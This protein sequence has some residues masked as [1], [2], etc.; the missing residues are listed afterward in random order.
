[1]FSAL[2]PSTSS[3][4]PVRRSLR[5]KSEYAYRAVSRDDLTSKSSA[6]P[7]TTAPEESMMPWNGWVSSFLRDKLGE[8]RYQSLRKLLLYRPDDY[9][10]FEQ[11][12][13]PNSQLP[14][15][16]EDPRLNHKFRQPSPGSQVRDC[17][18]DSHCGEFTSPHP[19]RL[20]LAWHPAPS[21]SRSTHGCFLW[22][23]GRRPLQ[24]HLL[25]T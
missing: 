4:A 2:R 7:A 9:T 18:F 11:M 21:V 16:K 19:K 6:S 3:L 1:M 12:P 13:R 15:S 10:G 8:D 25:Q 23:R 20:P 22:K 24:C 17:P 5:S 14:L